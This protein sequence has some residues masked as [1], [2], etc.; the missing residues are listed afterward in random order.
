MTEIIHFLH[1]HHFQSVSFAPVTG[2]AL[3]PLE[4]GYLCATAA[5]TAWVE[6]GPNTEQA[7]GPDEIEPVVPDIGP[8]SYPQADFRPHLYEVRRLTIKRHPAGRGFQTER[9][10]PWHS[11]KLRST[12]FMR[13]CHPR[14][15]RLKNSSTSAS[16]RIV[17]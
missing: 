3:R 2:D 12:A 6:L 7:G 1:E 15:L 14:P 17:T 8:P 11:M 10:S 16:K 13:P 4:F 9:R 5:A